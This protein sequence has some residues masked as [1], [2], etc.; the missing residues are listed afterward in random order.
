MRLP[1]L[2]PRI[3]TLTGFPRT[4]VLTAR[5]R[6]HDSDLP[7]GASGAADLI[8]GTPRYTSHLSIRGARRSIVGRTL[9][10]LFA[11]G[12]LVI[13]F[14]HYGLAP[15][16]EEH[17]GDSSTSQVLVERV[18]VLL[19]L[20]LLIWAR[21]VVKSVI[22]PPPCRVIV[23]GATLFIR[24]DNVVWPWFW[25]DRFEYVRQ[26]PEWERVDLSDVSQITL[27]WRAEAMTIY[28]R[29]RS[30]FSGVPTLEAVLD[31]KSGTRATRPF[32][33][34]FEAFRRVAAVMPTTTSLRMETFTLGEERVLAQILAASRSNPGKDAWS[35]AGRAQIRQF[36]RWG[37]DK[38]QPP[39]VAVI[40]HSDLSRWQGLVLNNVTTPE[41][42]DA[43]ILKTRRKL[44]RVLRARRAARL[45]NPP[46]FSPR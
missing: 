40:D 30:P 19:G 35:L 16:F 1:P 28:S 11:G 5:D 39:G 15:G 27:S 44:R 36:Y 43:H 3:L 22:K 21:A 9:G 25:F 42:Y 20:S 13:V 33:L 18:T 12:V 46:L 34:S 6:Y 17:S 7:E 10:L 45:G 4:R 29:L 23:D 26:G 31:F 37:V 32:G 2:K 8:L 24:R 38:P 41:Q 14:G